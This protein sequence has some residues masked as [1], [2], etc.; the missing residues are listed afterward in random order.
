MWHVDDIKASHHDP[1]VISN[2]I[3]WLCKTYEHIFEDRLG[4]LKIFH[5]PVDEYL[6]MQLDFSIASKVKL[7]MVPY[8]QAMLAKFSKHDNTHTMAKTPAA[9]HLFQINNDATPLFDN[10]AVAFHTFMAKALFLTKCTCPDLAMQ[11]LSSLH[12][13]HVWIRMTGKSSIA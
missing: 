12:A 5:G 9:Q 4:A 7:T 13:S 11:L 8:V 10:V 3:E 6:G 2:Y 1:Q